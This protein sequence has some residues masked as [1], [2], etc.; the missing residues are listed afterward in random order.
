MYSSG[1]SLRRANQYTALEGCES[2]FPYN[3]TEV[4]VFDIFSQFL[5]GQIAAIRINLKENDFSP[6]GDVVAYIFIFGYVYYTKVL[7]PCFS[8]VQY[9]RVVT[10]AME[11]IYEIRVW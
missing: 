7:E 5:I 10:S 1:I 3:F 4:R 11:S 9:R 2:G 6:R 8:R